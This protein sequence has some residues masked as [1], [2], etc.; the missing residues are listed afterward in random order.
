MASDETAD[1]PT[2]TRDGQNA[3]RHVYGPR[4]LAA[5]LPGVL[6]PAYKR[7]SPAASQLMLDW[8]AIVGPSLAA[9]T[10]PRKLFSGTLVIVCSGPVAMELQH[11]SDVVIARINGYLGRIAVTRL[12]FIQDISP[13][14]FPSRPPPRPAIQAAESAVAGLPPGELRDALERLGRVVLTARA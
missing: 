2:P 8:E 4:Q 3:A 6:R 14:P 11:L 13:A 7:R 10:A 12:R 9:S 5:V 1:N